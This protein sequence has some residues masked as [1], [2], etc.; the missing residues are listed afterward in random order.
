MVIFINFKKNST[1]NSMKIR[2]VATIEASTLFNLIR[3]TFVQS[4]GKHNTKED[5]DHYVSRNLSNAVL[6][7]EFRNPSSA[8]YFL[9]DGQKP[10][11]YLKLNTGLAQTEQTF[12][13]GLEVERI[14]I[15]SN[16]Q[17]KGLGSLL[18][19]FSISI[20][21]ESSKS[22]IWLGVWEHN[23][24]AIRFYERY[25]F[26]VYGSH[27]FLL[28]SDLQKDMLMKKDLISSKDL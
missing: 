21:M 13:N 3:E 2:K 19:D 15:S 26:S 28:G 9:E 4:F 6:D 8:F 23:E 16:Y 27:D 17:G 25:G 5:M 18:M 24:G 14:Y 1:L 20:A 7:A 11:G 12:N 10:I 22:P